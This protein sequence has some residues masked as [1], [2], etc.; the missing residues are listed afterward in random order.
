MSGHEWEIALL[1]AGAVVAWYS[2]RQENKETAERA[3]RTE[4][5]RRV[6]ERIGRLERIADF[7]RGRRAGTRGKARRN[8]R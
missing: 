4:H 2:R 7:E 5:A 3:E 1:L 6:G 8:D